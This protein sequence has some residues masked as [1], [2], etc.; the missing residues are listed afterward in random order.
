MMKSRQLRWK[1]HSLF[2]YTC[3]GCKTQH[4]KGAGVYLDQ[5]GLRTK[6][7]DTPQC[8]EATLANTSRVQ[9]P[10]LI[11]GKSRIRPGQITFTVSLQGKDL[12]VTLRGK[13]VEKVTMER[14]VQEL[15]RLIMDDLS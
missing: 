9:S 3:A 1:E 13:D 11:D 6:T 7:Y 10:T 5:S 14:F 15:S 4:E 8:A 2:P 12:E